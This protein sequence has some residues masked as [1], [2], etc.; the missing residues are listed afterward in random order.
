MPSIIDRYSRDELEQMVKTSFYLRDVV[1]KIGYSCVSG[2]N[3]D[4]VR[5]RLEK[6]NISTENFT[7]QKPMNRDES[8]I[9][10]E[11]SSAS[12]ATLRRW[13]KKR[14]KCDSCEICGQSI[15]WNGKPLTMILDHI[16]GDKHDNRLHNLRWICPNC[17]SQLPT[18]AGRNI[19]SNDNIGT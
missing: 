16:N 13:Y 1:K 19:K 10:C 18:Y 5:K 7:H 9:F 17:D 3:N 14:N 11:N 6:F 4:T 8:N 12:Q 2:R 15:K